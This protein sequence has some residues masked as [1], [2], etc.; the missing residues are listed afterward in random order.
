MVIWIIA[1]T[2]HR[3]LSL[4]FLV[5]IAR[6][7]IIVWNYSPSWNQYSTRVIF[8]RFSTKFSHFFL[9]LQEDI[10]AA[11]SQKIHTN[12]PEVLIR[13]F[14][15]FIDPAIHMETIDNSC[16]W[17]TE[18]FFKSSLKVLIQMICCLM[19]M[20]FV[21]SSTKNPHFVL[22]QQKYSHY[23]LLLILLCWNV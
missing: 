9:I 5:V 18:I 14:S 2:L 11:C 20:M 21:W 19:A 4:W 15:M 16:L 6:F 1:I 7:L 10:T 17:L 12:V 22:L 23:M 13:R 8:V 3:S